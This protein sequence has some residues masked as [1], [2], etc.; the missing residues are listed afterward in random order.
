MHLI[1][2][3]ECGQIKIFK[4]RDM[5]QECYNKYLRKHSQ[6]IYIKRRVGGVTIK[7][8]LPRDKVS[9]KGASAFIK[10]RREQILQ[11][12]LDNPRKYLDSV[13]DGEEE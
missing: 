3:K 9:A 2:C 7:G 8:S 10:Y 11:D 12:A 13:G 5:C 1:R 6:N 4:A